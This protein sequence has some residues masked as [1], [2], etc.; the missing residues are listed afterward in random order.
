MNSESARLALEELVRRKEAKERIKELTG[1]IIAEMFPQQI[2][3]YR[4]PSKAKSALCTRRAGKTSMWVRICT[5][6]ALENDRALIRIWATSRVR[7]KQQLWSE[8][9]YLFKRHGIKVDRNET[10]LTIRFEN[11]S[12][13]RLLGADKDKEVQK[14]RGDKTWLEVVLEAQLFGP[15]LKPLVED[16]AE[17]C[18]LDERA[19]GGGVFCLE[20]TPGVVCAGYWYEI[21]GQNPVDSQ[22]TTRGWSL[23]RWSVK[24]NPHMRHA[25]AEIERKRIERG[26]TTQEPTYMREYLAIWVNDLGAL[27]YH[28]DPANN[29]QPDNMTLTGPGWSH[30]L[31]WDLG[32]RDDMAL[33][34]WAW[35]D[36]DPT[37]YEY[38]SWKR[39]GASAD[40][41]M[42][43]VDQWEREGCKFVLKVA[44][45]GGGGRMYVDEVHRRFSHH[46]EAA[47]KTDKYQHVRLFN[48]DLKRRSIKLRLGSLYQQEIS[49]LPV[50]PSYKEEVLL[51]TE[52]LPYEDARFAN[53][54]CDAGLYAYRAAYHF[55][56]TEKQQKPPVGTADY[57][58]QL[59][60]RWE[61]ELANQPKRDWWEPDDENR[62]F[63]FD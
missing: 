32:A 60:A 18:L 23:H 5:C 45:T 48:D 7:C 13:I 51:N 12:E 57:Y 46:F 53:H 17:P 1:R 36:N 58:A 37:L 9:E 55:L 34:A 38:A 30:A 19:R 11:G 3:F 21:S 8:F 35:H 33:V 6:E 61:A 28:F 44:D 26:W 47:K 49:Q 4:D 43:Q 39:P 31:G 52:L 27:F 41:V 25:W 40:E 15:L 62:D 42:A 50:D 63:G 29:L 22:W 10:E 24:D 14:K 56:H 20:G 16:V 54:C 2:A 59:E